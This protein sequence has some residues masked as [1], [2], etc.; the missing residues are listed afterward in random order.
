VVWN[1]DVVVVVIV[2]LPNTL[3]TGRL[4]DTP[5]RGLPTR[6]LVSSREIAK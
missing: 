6:G 5:S 2:V 4:A 1:T 3:V